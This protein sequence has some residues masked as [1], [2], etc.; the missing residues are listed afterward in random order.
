M[1]TNALEL[2]SCT[3]DTKM[4]LCSLVVSKF[5]ARHCPTS[6]SKVVCGLPKC[7]CRFEIITLAFPFTSEP[8]PYWYVVYI[9]TTCEWKPATCMQILFQR[10]ATTHTF[11]QTNFGCPPPI[12]GW[13]CIQHYDIF[14]PYWLNVCV[15][16]EV[17]DMNISAEPEDVQSLEW[18]EFLRSACAT[19][20][21]WST[22]SSTYPKEIR[23]LEHACFL[24]ISI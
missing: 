12:N 21:G 11:S 16:G 24:Y 6:F 2:A 15:A 7:E 3:V 13:V 23:M 5:R 17:L 22:S 1:C 10:V 9:A 20:M 19:D 14:L 4:D 8:N 18:S